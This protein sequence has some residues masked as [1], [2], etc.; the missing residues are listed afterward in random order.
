LSAKKKRKASEKASEKEKLDHANG[1]K[2]LE[3][4]SMTEAEVWIYLML[5]RFLPTVSTI[6]KKKESAQFWCDPDLATSFRNYFRT[7]TSFA[8][9]PSRP[10]VYGVS[11]AD[12]VVGSK[13]RRAAMMLSTLL[14]NNSSYIDDFLSLHLQTKISLIEVIAG[15]PGA[16]EPDEVRYLIQSVKKLHELGETV[17]VQMSEVGFNTGCLSDVLCFFRDYPTG[18]KTKEVFQKLSSLG[19]E[20]TMCFAWLW[21]IA[22]TDRMAD[23]LLGGAF[24]TRDGMETTYKTVKS[25]VKRR[26]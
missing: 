9:E 23:M 13:S 18:F 2:M 16:N 25:P 17:G 3:G 5:H 24:L 4:L 21:S 14:A 1:M 20:S 15:I 11:A 26:I 10:F 22:A 12:Y 7:S 19:Y 6:A 8:A